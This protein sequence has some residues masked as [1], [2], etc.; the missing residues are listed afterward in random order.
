MPS[1][2]M[3]ARPWNCFDLASLRQL[4]VALLMIQERSSGSS[5]FVIF[6]FL[7]FSCSYGTKM[8]ERFRKSKY[9]HLSFT[10]EKEKTQLFMMHDKF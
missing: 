4:L 7:L 1:R 6:V 8:N 9:D 2:P 10:F 3:S 5:T